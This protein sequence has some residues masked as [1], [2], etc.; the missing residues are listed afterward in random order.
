VNDLYAELYLGV[1]WPTIE[2]LN[3]IVSGAAHLERDPTV[4]TEL[5]NLGCTLTAQLQKRPSGIEGLL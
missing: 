5:K 1:S 4:K 3:A 2:R